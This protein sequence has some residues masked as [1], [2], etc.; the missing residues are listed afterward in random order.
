MQPSKKKFRAAAINSGYSS[1][2]KR[3]REPSSSNSP[4][5]SPTTIARRHSSSSSSK[6]TPRGKRQRKSC[7]SLLI[8]PTGDKSLS[9][10]GA[11]TPLKPSVLLY[12][13]EDL[14]IVIFSFFVS[15]D[16]IDIETF[17]QLQLVD[18]KFNEVVNSPSLW[19]FVPLQLPDGSLNINTML[20]IKQ[21][22]KGTEGTCFH[23]KM[24]ADK[25][26][27]ALKRARVYPDNEGVP[28]YMLRELAALKK[29]SHP[30]ISTPIL[31]NLKH[32]KLYLLLPY[33][34]KT[35]H[36]YLNPSGNTSTPRA[37]LLVKKHQV[38][39]IMAQICSA[40]AHIHDKGILHR[41]LKPKHL[42]IVPG[43]GADPLDGAQVRLSDFALV[44]VLRHPPKKLTN[45]VVTLWYRPP[46]ILMGQR[47]YTA[48]VDI[49]SIGCIFA[50]LL[51]GKALFVGL[52]EID[53]L[54]QIFQT[55]GTPDCSVWPSFTELPYY[56][57]VIFPNF[58]INRLASVV[59]RAD[60]Q[61]L[62]FLQECLQF[63]PQR[64]V[65]AE[66][67][68]MHPYLEGV[69]IAQHDL[70]PPAAMTRASSVSSMCSV[71]SSLS[72]STSIATRDFS[73]PD[74]IIESHLHHLHKTTL[75]QLA[76]LRGLES[77]RKLLPDVNVLQRD[78]EWTFELREATAT[79][80]LHTTAAYDPTALCQRAAYFAI[81]LLDEYYARCLTPEKLKENSV[82]M[83]SSMDI[84]GA[85]C[86]H[87]AS[88]CEDVS[89]IGIR[90]LAGSLQM[91]YEAGEL[92][93]VE[94]EILNI[95][96]FDLYIPT[97]I[98]FLSIYLECVPEMNGVPELHS[99][100]K[101][102]AMI[103]LLTIDFNA[104]E[105]SRVA[106]AIVSYALSFNRDGTKAQG[107]KLC[108]WPP[109]LAALSQYQPCE[110][111]TVTQRLQEVQR[112]AILSATPHVV[113][114]QYVTSQHHSV[115][116][117]FP[118]S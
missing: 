90:D 16:R 98:D 9:S 54:F 89:F 88:K 32:F 40:V 25:S 24:R 77:Q 64:R 15:R 113:F 69:E 94:E 73:I 21:K 50:E 97:V 5:E 114:Q 30:H 27:V 75:R 96:Q 51:Q 60:Q 45:E 61:E 41:N 91:N 105:P 84:V 26:D 99:L 86:M 11:R 1:A 66:E 35:L 78:P 52:C 68:R 107:A 47:E 74:D 80:V 85:C 83:T 106:A 55:L 59:S 87:I 10:R 42:L 101:Y 13:P 34:E 104:F 18:R 17:S 112:Q 2:T 39:S 102:L 3:N 19:K 36:D 33:V 93:L 70:A 103:T 110:L 63:S 12:L 31:V 115:A 43:P 23:V 48:A 109:G 53:Q 8:T 44:R 118:H 46:E 108:V 82:I 14:F 38:R 22:N 37:E 29:L 92:L 62:G 116:R 111:V 28:Y 6:L 56:Q 7:S 95:F 67:C 100:C 71:T 4:L 49:W 58:E 81:A 117:W 57:D 20:L 76:F 65:S 72:R 79:W